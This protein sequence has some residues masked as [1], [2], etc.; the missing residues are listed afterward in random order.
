LEFE[1]LVLFDDWCL[2]IG[3]LQI[4]HENGSG[5]YPHPE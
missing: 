2:V 3:Y 4:I 1:Y 5:R